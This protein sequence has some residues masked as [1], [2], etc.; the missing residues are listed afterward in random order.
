[1]VRP[2][3]LKWKE[4]TLKQIN[5]VKNDFNI[6]GEDLERKLNITK[7]FSLKIGG[8]LNSSL[9]SR[10]EKIDSAEGN[11]HQSSNILC[12]AN[13]RLVK[14]GHDIEI[15]ISLSFLQKNLPETWATKACD[16]GKYP[17][18]PKNIS[19]N[20]LYDICQQNPVIIAKDS[21]G[22]CSPVGVDQVGIRMNL[23]T[24]IGKITSN[25]FINL[26]IAVSKNKQ[27]F[28]IYP[29]RG[30]RLCEATTLSEYIQ[31][32]ILNKANEQIFEL[33]PIAVTGNNSPSPENFNPLDIFNN[34][35]LKKLI[36]SPQFYSSQ[37]DKGLRLFGRS[38]T[39][40]KAN[41]EPLKIDSIDFD[42]AVKLSAELLRKG[43]EERT[44]EQINELLDNISNEAEK[45]LEVRSEI[46]PSRT[47]ILLTADIKITSKIKVDVAIGSVT[48]FMITN[49]NIRLLVVFSAF[50]T[51]SAK[52]IKYVVNREGN[53]NYSYKARTRDSDRILNDRLAKEFYNN[54]L[55]ELEKT[56][57]Q[58]SSEFAIE[59]EIPITD[60]ASIK[61][62]LS[63]DVFVLFIT[64]EK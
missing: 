50:S 24:A 48:G 61:L 52:G 62:R 55:F 16:P 15:F 13:R 23:T 14:L 44:R 53:V 39:Q 49:I 21:K 64:T 2:D 29:T 11:F 6:I 8:Q 27:K 46:E 51:N 60:A 4:S 31:S 1:M 54:S 18:A 26:T 7:E 34:A 9:L 35:D 43:L 63:N 30:T 58:K 41:L 37:I 40:L 56:V 12:T 3:Y 20:P 38:S 19:I 57:N 59:E 10:L 36:G 47:A 32:E 45:E 22:L 33:F 5:Q 25:P 28:E 17:S 42:Y